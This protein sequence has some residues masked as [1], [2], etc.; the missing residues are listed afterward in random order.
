[1]NVYILDP[2][3]EDAVA[4]FR[5]MAPEA[6]VVLWSDSRIAAWPEE[7]DAIIVRSSRVTG[8]DIRKSARLKVIGRHGA[9]YDKVDQTAARE[10]GIALLNTPFE[11]TE[12][13]AELVVTLMLACARNLGAGMEVV[14]TG[15]WKNKG[16]I[17]S[18]ELQGKNAGFVGYGRIARSAAQKLQ[19]AFGMRIHAYDPFVTAEQWS[20]L[21]PEAV[22]CDTLE[23][24]FSQ[25]DAFSIHVP[26]TPETKELICGDVLNSAK[27][28]AILINTARGGIVD[29]TALY[30]ALLSGK[31]MAAAS[32][33]FATEP[34]DAANPLFSLSNFI[35]TPHYGGSTK[36]A[37]RRVAMAVARE[38]A[39]FLHGGGDA[40]YRVL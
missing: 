4:L 29:E 23:D 22:R 5:E 17:R 20:A 32:D 3:H 35:P 39:A 8:D 30:D 2:I 38:V 40:R 7:A 12:A 11:N 6:D 1:M 25:C 21:S 18:E 16:K 24:L 19:A 14:K 36:E 27:P 9:G 15:Q 13:V 37:T 28:G 10:R 31:L 26:F 33:V 34:P